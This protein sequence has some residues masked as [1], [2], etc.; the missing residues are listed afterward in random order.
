MFAFKVLV[1]MMV[2]GC[3]LAEP[4]RRRINSR[5]QR[6][7][8]PARQVAAEP[9]GYSYPKPTVEYGPPQEEEEPQ[10][11]DEIFGADANAVAEAEEPEDEPQSEN[12]RFQRLRSQQ[13]RNQKARLQKLTQHQQQ[14]QQQF[15]PVQ[16]SF[17]V[18]YPGNTFP[19][20]Q[21]VY[22]F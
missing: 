7:R 15:L 5:F 2:V 22:V 12:I 6:F 14:Q 10:P 16:P 9:E 1:A 13:R 19:Q 18:Q 17:L 20:T 11:T 21:F 3:V 8:L 4:P